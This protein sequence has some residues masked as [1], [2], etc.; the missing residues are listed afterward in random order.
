MKKN[1]MIIA[2]ISAIFLAGCMNSELT[3]GLPEQSTEAAGNEENVVSTEE[4]SGSEESEVSTEESI[5]SN[6]SALSSEEN[7]AEVELTLE[8]K[9]TDNPR[10][11]EIL[12]IS[13]SYVEIVGYTSNY[14][15]QIPQF[16]ADSESAKL[17]N[18]RIVD[19]LYNIIASEVESISKGYSQTCYSVTYEVIEYGNIVAI[20]VTI[21]YP[22]DIMHYYTYSYDFDNHKEVTNTELLAMKGWTEE[23]FLEE[24][25]KREKEYFQG[26]ING[27][28]AEMTEAELNAF[29][30]PALDATSVGLSM[31]ID[32]DSVLNVYVPFPS[33]AGAEWYYGLEQF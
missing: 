4:T 22:N 30:Q 21:P 12:N 14:T 27:V 15:Y 9:M 8:L 11:A 6:E 25:Y 29:I 19:D 23:A 20:L 1:L 24:A 3:S 7:V 16:N 31:Y 17:V 2:I 10:I 5:S 13:G 26:F 33:V 18:E 28:Y 32:S